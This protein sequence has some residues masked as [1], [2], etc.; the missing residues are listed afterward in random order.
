M[1]RGVAPK[2]KI[3]VTAPIHVKQLLKHHLFMSLVIVKL[4]RLMITYDELSEVSEKKT[5]Q[6]M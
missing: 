4:S 3:H 1:R 2:K 5:Y 6:Q